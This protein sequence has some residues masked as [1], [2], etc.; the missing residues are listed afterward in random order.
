MVG[1]KPT[2]AT[3]VFEEYD[4]IDMRLGFYDNRKLEVKDRMYPKSN[5]VLCPEPEEANGA[6]HFKGK[7]TH[8]LVEHIVSQ[9]YKL[10]RF[11]QHQA[12]HRAETR[13]MHNVL[14][15]MKAHVQ[16]YMFF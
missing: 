14:L 11:S 2:L 13:A 6:E 15:Y 9:E 10:D 4:K 16:V 5:W 8:E 3:V 12:E 7:T 1:E